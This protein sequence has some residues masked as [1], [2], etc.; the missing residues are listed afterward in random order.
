MRIGRVLVALIWLVPAASLLACPGDLHGLSSCSAAAQAGR[1]LSFYLVAPGLWLGSNLSQA[2]VEPG[3]GA[4]GP[5]FV[6]GI[7]LWLV[8]LSA[9]TLALARR[10]ARRA[11]ATG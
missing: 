4:S 10:F 2:L 5:A 6:A 1:T 9:V 11:T 8:A 3:A 7:G